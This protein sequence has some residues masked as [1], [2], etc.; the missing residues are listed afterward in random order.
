MNYARGNWEKALLLAAALMMVALPSVF[1]ET[2]KTVVVL[3]DSLAAGFGV[4]PGE[5]YPALLQGKI[6]AAGLPYTIVDAGVSGDTTSDGLGR[7][8]WLLR[9]KMDVLIV[10]LGGNDGLRGVPAATIQSNLQAIIDRARKKYPAIKIVIAGMRMPTNLGADYVGAFA[11]VFPE[12][13]RKNQT[14]LVPFLL[15][16]VGGDASLNQ[17]DG[18][19]PTAE[20][21]KLLAEN[22]WKVLKPILESGG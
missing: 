3:G 13:A 11:R 1:A 15:E 10:E 17:A 6:N 5:A 21:H 2:R 18:I 19:H 16:G 4:E 22:V 7:I 14:A 8:D 9:R 12:I 20:G